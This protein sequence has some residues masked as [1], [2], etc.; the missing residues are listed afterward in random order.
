MSRW[1]VEDLARIN[2]SHDEFLFADEFSYLKQRIVVCSDIMITFQ[3]SPFTA[4]VVCFYEIA[5]N[6]SISHNS[7]YCEAIYELEVGMREWAKSASPGEI[8]SMMA[9]KMDKQGSF[10][11]MS[12][13]FR[14][15]LDMMRYVITESEREEMGLAIA[16]PVADG[17]KPK[18]GR[19]L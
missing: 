19:A 13:R 9:E 5:A 2:G 16:M 1:T 7:A 10:F 18:K 6:G 11:I 12:N 4:T 14:S 3:W 17:S 8:A 15:A